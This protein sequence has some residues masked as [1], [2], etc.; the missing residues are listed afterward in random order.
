MTCCKGCKNGGAGQF[1]APFARCVVTQAAIAPVEWRGQRFYPSQSILL[2]AWRGVTAGT[3]QTLVGHYQQVI[4]SLTDQAMARTGYEPTVP[5]FNLLTQPG[6]AAIYRA[7]ARVVTSWWQNTPDDCFLMIDDDVFFNP[8]DATRIIQRCREMRSIVCGAYSTKGATHFACQLYPD[9]V[10]SFGPDAPLT[11]IKYPATG[12]MAVHRDVIDALIKT[13]PLCNLEYTGGYYPLFRPLLN[14]Y[15]PG[16]WEELTED[17]SFGERARRAGFKVY[18]DPS[19]PIHH[20]GTYRWTIEDVIRK[21]QSG[22]AYLS[23]IGDSPS[24][25]LA[26]DPRLAE[27]AV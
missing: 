24:E 7:R 19:I 4:A 5:M 26:A 17:Y 10:V 14:E 23:I 3:L 27:V 21:I 2:C 9:Q 1:P 8:K 13:E 12:F 16:Q 18:L 6:D 20:E 25:D 15:M 11:E 22:G